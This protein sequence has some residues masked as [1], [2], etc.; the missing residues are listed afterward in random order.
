MRLGLL[1]PS[2][3][4]TME[5]ELNSALQK[6]TRS[7][8]MHTGRL[9]LK[10]VD[11]RSLLKM[12]EE[13]NVEIKKLMDAEVDY[14]LY[15][16]T[17]GSLLQGKSYMMD[18]IDQMDRLMGTIGKTTTTAMCVLDSLEKLS[19]KKISVITPYSKEINDLEEKFLEENGYTVALIHGMGLI[20]NLQIGKVTQED[21]LNFIDKFK[22]V[23]VQSDA[24]FISCTNL[25]T[26]SSLCQLEEKLTVPVVS[27]NSASLYK[28]L[29][30]AQIDSTILSEELG[31][32]FN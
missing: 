32:L 31:V 27:S 14:L 12:K 20:N 9:S 26:F 25:P 29:E 23:I 3:N 8:S 22:E 13:L 7:L 11:S 15:G 4:S 5:P 28:I 21:L 24:L 1:V 19:V 6:L 18:L 17:S 16:C 30:I 10:K 2:S